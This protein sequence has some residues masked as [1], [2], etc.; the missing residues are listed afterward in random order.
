MTPLIA[1][2]VKY[3]NR[4]TRRFVGLE[5]H[6]APR[7]QEDILR[8]LST[9]NIETVIDVGANVG[10]FA[11]WISPIF[12]KAQIYCFEPLPDCV[13]T[14][15]EKS[16]CRRGTMHVFPFACGETSRQTAFYESAFSPKI[17]RASCR[18]RV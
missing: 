7:S 13:Q 1:K 2:A 5:V 9:F 16:S 18:E 6:R 10:Q 12:P 15:R 14:L 8:W 11:D 3:C 17:G 4:I